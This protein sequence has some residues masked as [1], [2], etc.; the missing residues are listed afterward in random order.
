MNA[1]KLKVLALLVS[2]LYLIPDISHGQEAASICPEPIRVG[3]DDWAPYA[4]NDPSGKAVGLDVDMLTLVANHLGC[5]LIFSH[6]PAKRA[7]QMLKL[8]TL[9]MMMGASY[10][11]EREV[12]ADFS[13]SYRNEEIKLFV[14]SEMASRIKIEKWSDIMTKQLKLLAPVYGWYGQDYLQSKNEL[15]RQG[16][17]VISPNTA[18]SVQML[19]YNRG[20][21]LIGDA[22]S[23][24][25]VASLSENIALT[26]LAFL[27]DSN[28]IH[29]LLSKKTNN[30]I[31]LTEVNRAILALSSR[32]AL[33][34][35]I[36]KWQ[37]LAVAQTQEVPSESPL[38]GSNGVMNFTGKGMLSREP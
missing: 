36:V 13:D 10:M 32:G 7:H 34:R 4:W 27:V 23:L 17:L 15:I 6:M 26:P 1:I 12:Y 20:D 3:F 16:L 38:D 28:K 24:P 33:A 31:L 5:K 21:I 8:G 2:T 37:Q 14:K 19:A 11:Q 22:I 35:V 30:P 29:F 18:Q 25:Y 9:D